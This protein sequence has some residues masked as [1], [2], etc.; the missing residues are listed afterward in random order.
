MNRLANLIR[1]AGER[2]SR[3]GQ[4]TILA[5]INPQEAALLKLLGG[6][7]RPDPETG[8]IHFDDGESSSGM[9][10]GWSGTG[11]DEGDAA[12][13]AAG[14][15]AM[16]D[17]SYGSTDSAADAANAAAAMGG[18]LD[19]GTQLSM[20][21]DG[22]GKGRTGSAFDKGQE[23]EGFGNWSQNFG[24]SLNSYGW[25][26]AKSNDWLTGILGYDPSKTTL[27]DAIGS[28]KGAL[29]FGRGDPNNAVAARSEDEITNDMGLSGARSSRSTTTD[30]ARDEYNAMGWRGE[31]TDNPW[32]Y[33]DLEGGRNTNWGAIGTS[34]ANVL[35]NPLTATVAGLTGLGPAYGVLNGAVQASRGNYTPGITTLANLSGIPN[36][37]AGVGI[38][39]NLINGTPGNVLAGLGTNY[40]N[41]VAPGS[42]ALLNL[43]GLPSL[44]SNEINQAYQ[45]ALDGARNNTV[46]GDLASEGFSGENIG[47]GPQAMSFASADTPSAPA[48]VMGGGGG[49]GDSSDY[50]DFVGSKKK[51]RYQRPNALMAM[52]GGEYA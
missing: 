26:S 49:P 14:D 37:A 7:G 40:L 18:N 48:A 46:S 50:F 13:A 41:S 21:E 31:L 9:D 16:S 10:G 28:A 6:S 1:A 38:A 23:L 43:S 32:T 12:A 17:E 11:S 2:N 25:D 35:N 19:F 44:A 42:G 8:A 27:D 22:T 3:G 51:S 36:A 45:S 30:A 33:T 39:S 29:G 4:D 24:N 5:H 15:N 20:D 47:E 52:T 34:A